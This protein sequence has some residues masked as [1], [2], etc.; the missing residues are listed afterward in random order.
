MFQLEARFYYIDILH[1]IGVGL[2]GIVY[3]YKSYGNDKKP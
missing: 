2:V 1:Q 3:G